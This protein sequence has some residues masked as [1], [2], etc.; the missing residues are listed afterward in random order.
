VRSLFGLR[1]IHPSSDL[2]E[3]TLTAIANKTGGRYFRARDAD[4]LGKIY[5][6]LDQLE[7]AAS[8]ERGFR[9]VAE[10]FYW[11]LG[12]A[13]AL[14]LISA[15][16]AVAAGYWRERAPLGVLRQGVRHGRLPIYPAMVGSV[17][18][19]CGVVPVADGGRARRRGRLA[20][21]RR[22]AAA[23]ARARRDRRAA[24]QPLAARRRARV[25]RAHAR[26]ARGSDMGAAARPRVPL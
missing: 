19:G 1:Q 3:T 16:G 14:A 9:P 26:G 18:A 7:P 23:R 20:E 24:R 12:A 25:R 22:R 11:P 2:D 10:L 13:L 15:L 6:I 17:V 5:G 8:D 21:R 4:E